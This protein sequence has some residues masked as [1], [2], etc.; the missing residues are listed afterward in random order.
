MVTEINKIC[1]LQQLEKSWQGFTESNHMTDPFAKSLLNRI[2]IGLRPY[3][4]AC[5][6]FLR[7]LVAYKMTRPSRTWSRI[8]PRQR[9]DLT[10]AHPDLEARL[11][12]A[13]VWGDPRPWCLH[14]PTYVSCMLRR[15]VHCMGLSLSVWCKPGMHRWASD[16]RNKSPLAEAWD[17]VS[18]WQHQ[19]GSPVDLG[20][21]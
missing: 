20:N 13:L 6:D 5:K 14:D 18:T 10:I 3:K 7:K 15:K 8:K 9:E 21:Q 16:A 12:Q 4:M 17:D 11:M 1:T 19:V 2:C